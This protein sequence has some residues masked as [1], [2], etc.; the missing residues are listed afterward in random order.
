[1][2]RKAPT[3]VTEF[4]VTLGDYERMKLDDL[5]LTLRI[6]S[7]KDMWATEDGVLRSPA[8]VIAAIYSI[9]TIIEA[10]G[11]DTPVPT[12]VDAYE[13]IQ[14]VDVKRE[15]KRALGAESNVEFLAR[16]LFGMN[17]AVA[18]S[19]IWNLYQYAQDVQAGDTSWSQ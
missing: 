10:M 4:R 2:P 6:H 12:P 11:I 18:G 15:A 16:V 14:G 3:T 17:P 5:L 7:L 13:F 1:M 9:V 19:N 8:A